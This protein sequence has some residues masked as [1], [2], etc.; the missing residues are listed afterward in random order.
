MFLVLPEFRDLVHLS[1]SLLKLSPCIAIFLKMQQRLSTFLG[2]ELSH[3]TIC[4]TNFWWLQ[5]SLMHVWCS[6]SFFL[7]VHSMSLVTIWPPKFVQR[8]GPSEGASE[9]RLLYMNLVKLYHLCHTY[10]DSKHGPH[11]FKR[12]LILG[13]DFCCMDNNLLERL[14]FVCGHLLTL[15]ECRRGTAELRFW[16]AIQPRLIMRPRSFIEV[17]YL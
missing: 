7:R 5:C 15:C 1:L 6:T 8:Q 3:S 16:P 13:G 4:N 2:M 9:N 17:K 14:S 12:T 11:I 10:E